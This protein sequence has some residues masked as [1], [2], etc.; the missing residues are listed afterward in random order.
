MQVRCLCAWRGAL[1]ASGSDDSTIRLSSL[2]TAR[3][4]AE[5]LGHKSSV[6]ALESG[7]AHQVGPTV[8]AT[9]DMERAARF[10]AGVMYL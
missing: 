5:L 3:L 4:Q 6:L 1:V 10:G 9:A 2:A 8:P 7:L